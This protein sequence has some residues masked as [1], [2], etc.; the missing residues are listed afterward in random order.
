M[1]KKEFKSIDQQINLLQERGL[2]INDV[3]RAKKYLLSNN[4]YNIINGYSKP[5]LESEN[6]YIKNASF[7]EV[8]RLYFFDKELKQVLF[9]S[10]L[11]AEHHLK[12]I[13]AHRF[14]EAHPNNPEAYL[15]ISS[16]NHEKSLS[17]A[18]VIN[19]LNGILRKNRQYRNNSIHHYSTKY[20]AVPIWV[21]IDYLTFGDLYALLNCLPDNLQNRVANDCT[22]F[23]CSNNP[24]FTGQFPPKTMLS[25]IKNIQ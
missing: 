3:E 17:V 10:I 6:L 1:H 8:S 20:N 7:D 13:L 23:I 15:D 9:N 25:F 19:S 12:S 24:N 14:A 21:I 4:Y 22:E 16:Y 5:F 11:D 18:H 2:T